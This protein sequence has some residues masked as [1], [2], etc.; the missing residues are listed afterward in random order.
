MLLAI[1]DDIDSGLCEYCAQP[2]VMFSGEYH[3]NNPLCPNKEKHMR[4]LENC[5]DRTKFTCN[6]CNVELEVIVEPSHSGELPDGSISI[7]FCPVCGDGNI[8][9]EDEVNPE[10]E[11]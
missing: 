5:G 11:N 9:H 3:C 4:T 10:L 2:L 6:N 1:L 7:D 8:A